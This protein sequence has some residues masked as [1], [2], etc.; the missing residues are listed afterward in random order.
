MFQLIYISVYHI[1]QLGSVC[2]CA[3]LS[4]QVNTT[5]KCTTVHHNIYNIRGYIRLIPNWQLH[6]VQTNINSTVY[7]YR[8]TQH[9]KVH[10]VQISKHLDCYSSLS[11]DQHPTQNA[12]W[13]GV[14]YCVADQRS[15]GQYIVTFQKQNS[16]LCTDQH[17]TKLCTGV[18]RQHVH[19]FII[20]HLFTTTSTGVA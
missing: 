12:L 6:C 15:R 8:S 20:R 16:S 2:M 5:V 9:W 4:V 11:I 7:W 19:Q 18:E 1:L 14:M 3:D 13:T 10:R 17:N